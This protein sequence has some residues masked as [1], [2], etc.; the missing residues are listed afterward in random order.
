VIINPARNPSIFR[1]RFPIRLW[2]PSQ[3]LLPQNPLPR[4]QFGSRRRFPSGPSLTFRFFCGLPCRSI[5]QVWGMHE[6]TRFK[7]TATGR[8]RLA[9]KPYPR[10][11]DVR[12]P[13]A[14]L[15]IHSI[16]RSDRPSRD[17]H[18][19][20]R[21]ARRET[22]LLDTTTRLGLRRFLRPR[23]KSPPRRSQRR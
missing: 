13:F 1:R 17:S 2:Y 21:S 12:L 19:R 5:I 11:A 8:S 3:H 4:S 15:I 20:C 9:R 10:S 7:L 14:S 6:R 16:A 18:R 22:K 23:P